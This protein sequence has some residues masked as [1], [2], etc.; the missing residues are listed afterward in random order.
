MSDLQNALKFKAELLK[1]YISGAI[2]NAKDENIK[3]FDDKI[4]IGFG[5]RTIKGAVLSYTSK[6]FSFLVYLFSE[7]HLTKDFSEFRISPLS[8][9]HYFYD[10]QISEITVDD[11]IKED[12]KINKILF[13]KP[14]TLLKKNI[15]EKVN[16]KRSFIHFGGVDYSLEVYKQKLTVTYNINIEKTMFREIKLVDID[17]KDLP[18]DIDSYMKKIK[19]KLN[20]LR[21]KHS[22]IYSSKLLELEKEMNDYKETL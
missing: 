1:T 11:I 17:L 13:S 3:I 19:A 4:G 15:S 22:E 6:Q 9:Y 14:F 2:K 21:E 20:K 12:S 8:R 16:P 7:E 5:E 18:E 10:H